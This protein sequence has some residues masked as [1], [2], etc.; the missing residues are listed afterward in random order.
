[1]ARET[2]IS[3]KYS[4]VVEG[5]ENNNLRDRI[6]KKLDG[7]GRFYNGEK[8]FSEDLS[9][10]SAYTIKE[11][12][13]EMIK[14]TTVT[15]VILSPNVLFSKWVDWEIQYSLREIPFDDYTSHT[16]G[17][18]AVVQ[19]NPDI[20]GNNYSWME[21]ICGNW[22]LNRC[23]KLIRDNRGNKKNW[24]SWSLAYDYIEIV[25]EDKFLINPNK[26][27]EEAYMKS[28]NIN[29]YKLTKSNYR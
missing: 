3:Y 26:Y 5:H 27:I 2:F 28:Q 25:S 12:L 24:A 20:W 10:Y 23:P 29:S 11:Y 17:I 19:K 4:D 6:I 1:M 14:G 9:G 22:D 7:A 13:K 8:K 18:V 21:D 15:I 16:N